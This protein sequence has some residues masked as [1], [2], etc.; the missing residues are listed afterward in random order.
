MIVR[1]TKKSDFFAMT[2]VNFDNVYEVEKIKDP[3]VILDIGANIGAFTVAVARKFPH[4]KVIAV[5]PEPSNF[6][7]LEKNIMRNNLTNVETH[8]CAVGA[9]SGYAQLFLDEKRDSAHSLLK[10]VGAG[11]RGKSIEVSV[12][13]LSHFG[14][15][16]ALKI[17]CEGS[18][19][20]ILDNNI[21]V[22]QYVAVEFDVG[23]EELG[24]Q[25]IQAGYTTDHLGDI[26]I[27]TRP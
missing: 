3:K 2:S 24:K 21:P 18:E 10:D 4:A 26:S 25:F 23:K 1:G 6:K 12:V 27:F 22:C 16:D 7:Q 9:N 14:E 11:G 19:L 8:Q 5:E 20:A 13:P 17:D 15:V